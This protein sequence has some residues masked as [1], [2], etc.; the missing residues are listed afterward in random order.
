MLASVTATSHFYVTDAEKL[1]LGNANPQ[2]SSDDYMI[3]P[4]EN[5]TI[6]LQIH[7]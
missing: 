6:T 4:A 7:S 5:R 2:V 1:D 3:C